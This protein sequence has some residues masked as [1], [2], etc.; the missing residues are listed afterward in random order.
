MGFT[1]INL[2]VSAA[3]CFTKTKSKLKM[4]QLLLSASCLSGVSLTL[5]K[6]VTLS[7]KIEN[8]ADRWLMTFSNLMVCGVATLTQFA[9]LNVSMSLYD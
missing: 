9:L 7:F 6:L 8:I 1:G 2:V 5:L 4:F 3:L